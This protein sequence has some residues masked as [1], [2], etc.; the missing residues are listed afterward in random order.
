MKQKKKM[1]SAMTAAQMICAWSATAQDATHAPNNQADA[2]YAKQLDGIT[3]TGSHIRSVDVETSQP[4]FT[5]SRQAIKATGLTNVSDILARMPSIGTP[6]ITPQ[7]TLS[8]GP[9]VGGTYVNIRNLGAARTLVL[10]NG[11]RWST[12]LSG[13]TDLSTIPVSMI[14]RIDVLKDGASSIYGSDAIGGV[15]NIITKDKFDGA[16]ANVYYGQNGKG[17]GQTQNYD[18]TWGHSTEKNSIIIGAAWQQTD[19]MWDNK[20]DETRYAN[21]ARHPEDGW[22]STGPYGRVVDPTTGK[23]YVYNHGG[24]TT[25]AGAPAG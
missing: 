14:D 9:D 5:M 13:L 11:R 7:D 20:R 25:T 24:Q 23:Q 16:E 22:S 1:A 17:D 15:V 3:V 4:V 18:F 12:S 19:P 6:D 2:G 8:S 10:V 21:G